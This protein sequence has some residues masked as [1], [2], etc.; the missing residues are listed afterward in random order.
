MMKSSRKFHSNTVDEVES[1]CEI[2]KIVCYNF[3]S[4]KNIIHAARKTYYFIRGFSWVQVEVNSETYRISIG[5]IQFWKHWLM[6]LYWLCKFC[7]QD[8]LV[9]F[10]TFPMSKEEL[11]ALWEV[12]LGK[13]WDHYG[14]WVVDCLAEPPSLRINLFGPG[15]QSI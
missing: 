5:K 3:L 13:R 2:I 10:W 4:C 11:W 7:T 14:Q 1:R 15:R 8:V 9:T 12:P 6:P